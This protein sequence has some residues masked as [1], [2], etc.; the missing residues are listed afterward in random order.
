M[1][2]IDDFESERDLRIL[3]EADR[4]RNDAGRLSKAQDHARQ[5]AEELLRLADKAQSARGLTR[6]DGA[7]SSK[8]RVNSRKK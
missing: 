5:R 8:T 2:G 4:I 1:P 6:I 3:D 7:T